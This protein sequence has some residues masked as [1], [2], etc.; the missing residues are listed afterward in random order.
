[1]KCGQ[2]DRALP[3]AHLYLAMTLG[4]LNIQDEFG[5]KQMNQCTHHSL[6]D[7]ATAR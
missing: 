6:S 3:K 5:A 1:M 2:D 7:V 4:R